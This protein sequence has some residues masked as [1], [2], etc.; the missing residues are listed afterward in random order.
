[1]PVLILSGDRHLGAIYKHEKLDIYEI[2][3][4]S[5][6]KK[7]FN[8]YEPDPLRIGPLINYNNFGIL[9]IYKEKIKVSLNSGQEM[10]RAIYNALE[11]KF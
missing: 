2:T 9:E 1:M 11:L 3:S 10:E 5:L 7:I 4:S 8:T 6:N